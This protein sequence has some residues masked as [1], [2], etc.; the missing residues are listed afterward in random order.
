MPKLPTLV[1]LCCLVAMLLS[2][3]SQA[4][5]YKWVDASGKIHYGDSPPE[6]A[7]LKNIQGTI[8]S[9]KSV[10]VEPFVFDPKIVSKRSSTK[11]VVMYSTSWC[12]YCK[13]AVRHFKKNKIQF[14][15]HDIEKSKKAAAEYRKLKGRGVPV[16]LIGKQRMNGFEAGAFDKIYYD[17][18]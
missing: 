16:I 11:T 3:T 8:S 18:S 1:S 4:E 17:K 12:G 9:F 2:P 13:K 15:E 6:N 5:F 14:T 10:T 7:Q